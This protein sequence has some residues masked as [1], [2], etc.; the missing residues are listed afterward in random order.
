MVSKATKDNGGVPDSRI[1]KL[2]RIPREKPLNRTLKDRYLLE[3]LRKL[4]PGQALAIQRTL[5]IIGDKDSADANAIKAS[6]LVMS[7]YA[8]L[9]KELY[10][11]DEVDEDEDSVEA[12]QEDAPKAKLFS[13][14]MI[15][16]NEP[17]EE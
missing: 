6:A 17:V 4:R 9:I 7:T 1:N 5:K 15:K 13:L 3:L 2:G 12:L 10:G 14:T 8:S 16:N 11:K